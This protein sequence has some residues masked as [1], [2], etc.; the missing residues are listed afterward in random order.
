M[1]KPAHLLSDPPQHCDLKGYISSY[2]LD[3]VKRVSGKRGGEGVDIMSM[4]TKGLIYRGLH[5]EL[6]TM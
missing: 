1:D 3:I 6:M 2:M 5:P 4:V